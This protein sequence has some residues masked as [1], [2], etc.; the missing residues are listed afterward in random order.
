MP[1]VLSLLL[2]VLSASAGAADV[3]DHELILE[4]ARRAYDA[5]EFGRV[6]VLME[7]L[8]R[9]QP[10]CAECAHLLGKAYGRLAERASWTRAVSYAKQAHLQLENAVL[11]D[12]ENANAL[13]DLIT[14]YRSAPGF[15]GGDMKKADQLEL[16][17]SQLHADN[18]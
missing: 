1:V 14:F 9:L 4:D 12:P 6:A 7:T 2:L 17:L 8:E 10:T 3:S 5:H 18:S 11:L 16:R 13:S 15:L